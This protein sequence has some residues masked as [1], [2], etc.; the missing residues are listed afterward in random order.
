MKSLKV[1]Y[2]SEMKRWKEVRSGKLAI[3]GLSDQADMREIPEGI[4]I[5]G[6]Q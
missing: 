3:N 5:N 6:G 4:L 2:C 1:G